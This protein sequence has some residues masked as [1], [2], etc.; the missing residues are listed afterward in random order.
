MVSKRFSKANNPYLKDF[1]PSKPTSYI[2]YLDANNLYDWAM[3][4][5][6]PTGKFQWLK[7]D[8]IDS[9]NINSI[10]ADSKEGY[11][12]EVYLDY[13]RELHDSHNAF[14]L[15]PESLNVPKEWMSD[16]QLDLIDH[17]PAPKVNKL[18]LNL[19][20]KTKYKLHYRNLQLYLQ[21]GM[22]LTKSHGGIK[23]NQEP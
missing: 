7:H 20:D 16:Y 11:I 5:P 23:F 3:S 9:L 1:D 22:K 17:Q 13:P 18:V 21:L 19:N 6:L 4:Q 15:A 12:L 8:E 14:P 10:A 2:S